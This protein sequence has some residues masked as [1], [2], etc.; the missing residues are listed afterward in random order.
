MRIYISS[1]WKNRD[2]VRVLAN[3]LRTHGDEV[4]DFTDP[5]CR[6]APEIPPEKFP[7]EFDPQTMNY[8]MYLRKYPEWHVAVLGNRDALDWCDVCVL[9]LPCGNDAHAD[10][11]YAV[12]RNKCTAVLGAPKKGDR[13]PV[14]LWAHA[15]FDD[16]FAF[17][18]WCEKL[19]C[20]KGARND[21]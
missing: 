5:K 19:R 4:Y 1:S 10:W 16:G 15:L 8:R 11:A 2:A 3:E 7:E 9:L 17:V 18:E 12:G 21:R 13:S 14:H 6:K 20:E